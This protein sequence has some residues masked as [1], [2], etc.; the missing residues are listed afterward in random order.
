MT[1]SKPA[2]P[3]L[4]IMAALAKSNLSDLVQ[5]AEIVA[6]WDQILRQGLPE[7]LAKHCGLVSWDDGK[8]LFQASSPVWKNKL[9]LHSQEILIRANAA[10][11]HARE[12]RIRI[13]PAMPGKTNP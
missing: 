10:G 8:L 9:R 2:K 5:R 13:N 1:E 6:A 12:I 11:L 7:S 4:T 3:E